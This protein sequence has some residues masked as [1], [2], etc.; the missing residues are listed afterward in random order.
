MSPNNVPASGNF[1]GRKDR[2]L[3]IFG[4]NF[5]LWGK[6]P[7]VQLKFIQDNTFI[8][9]RPPELIWWSENL[10]ECQV[11]IYLIWNGFYSCLIFY[12]A[13]RM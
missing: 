8:E 9:I 11:S 6:T 12:L 3:I 4:S 13:S 1:P 2:M 5:L 7:I 10:L